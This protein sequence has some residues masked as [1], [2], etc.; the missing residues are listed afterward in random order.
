MQR[1]SNLCMPEIH[2]G[3]L[4][5]CSFRS[6]TGEFQA[7]AS[8]Q[9]HY[10]NKLQMIHGQVYSCLGIV[11]S[12][13]SMGTK[14]SPSVPKV[15]LPA[16]SSINKKSCVQKFWRAQG[17][18]L[19]SHHCSQEGERNAG[20]ELPA[21]VLSPFFLPLVLHFSFPNFSWDFPRAVE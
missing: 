6:P 21:P 9:S 16:D 2:S 7:E 18:I 8:P 3:E 19:F 12:H 15:Q 11:A 14:R 5:N 13:T 1:L 10:S 4:F 17:R 20:M